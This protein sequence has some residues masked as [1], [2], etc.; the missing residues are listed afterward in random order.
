MQDNCVDVRGTGKSAATTQMKACSGAA[1]QRFTADPRDGRT[2]AEVLAL[3]LGAP[4]GGG[5]GGATARP[6][7]A[8]VF[9]R[10]TTLVNA[11]RGAD[12]VSI[13]DG[14]AAL[15]RC[16]GWSAPGQH[17][18]I[19][20]GRVMSGA[21][22]LEFAPAARVVEGGRLPGGLPGA[23]VARSMGEA[24]IR[25][26]VASVPCSLA[27]EQRFTRRGDE[28]V[29][30][31][32][33]CVAPTPDALGPLAAVLGNRLVA[34]ACTG[35]ASQ[36]FP[37]RPVEGWP[38]PVEVGTFV[39][40]TETGRISKWIRAETCPTGPCAVG[41]VQGA[42][43]VE[44]TT[45]FVRK[46]GL[47]DPTAASFELWGRP[48]HWLRRDGDHLRLA[49]FEDS[50]AFRADATFR[51]TDVPPTDVCPNPPACPT[52]Y[53]ALSPLSRP[54][55]FVTR[56]GDEFVIAPG[57]VGRLGT[58]AKLGLVKMPPPKNYV[59]RDPSAYRPLLSALGD[60]CLSG[61]SSGD[62]GWVDLSPCTAAPGQYWG[63][64]DDGGLVNLANQLCLTRRGAPS[65]ESPYATVELK[66]CTGQPDQRWARVGQRTFEL[67]HDNFCLDVASPYPLASILIDRREGRPGQTF[68]VTVPDSFKRKVIADFSP[69]LQFDRG[70]KYFPSSVEFFLKHM[71]R[72]QR[73]YPKAPPKVRDWQGK[74][75]SLR[76]AEALPTPQS[77]LK[78]FAGEATALEDVP[79]YAFWVPRGGD[80]V[81]VVY[82]IFYPYNLGKT[83]RGFLK[84][85]VRLLDAGM[86]LLGLRAGKLSFETPAVGN[87]VGDWEHVTARVRVTWSGDTPKV[88]PLQYY[89]ASHDEGLTANYERNADGT[90]Q[91]TAKDPDPFAT[92]PVR[93]APLD[94]M[95]PQTF[96]AQGSHGSYLWVGEH[97]YERLMAE[98]ISRGVLSAFDIELDSVE[99]MVDL[100]SAGRVWDP[101]A[102]IVAWDFGNQAG[103]TGT[104]WPSWLMEGG[105]VLGSDPS[106]PESGSIYRWGNAAQGMA[107]STENELNDGPVGPTW[108]DVLPQDPNNPNIR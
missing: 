51:A 104:A 71:V 20:D 36:A 1:K 33:S 31:D 85:P 64:N 27:P 84:A 67:R 70:E 90:Y 65:P 35:A 9:E 49:P 66:K 94:G 58:E 101:R 99:P 95:R 91:L 52:V 96:V 34:V 24:G 108:K 43:G 25:G 106:R 76:T 23:L 53:T 75:W 45:I 11:L 30:S 46:T 89:F 4:A 7:P 54:G 29:V 6:E 18:R 57:E 8:Y 16:E 93:V 59:P 56:R 80:I 77:T 37:L 72:E 73:W 88:E 12:C 74:V 5:G 81:D 22:C 32:G 83:V 61:A 2:S 17:F 47:A 50:L 103:L 87:H 13:A 68:L 63:V 98:E 40:F 28:L 82:Y 78:Y 44:Q 39:I 41:L 26:L 69:I 19:Q 100:T 92:V 21:T 97:F 62:S 107:L 3:L 60:K 55:A 42:P 86:K 10:P 105:L 14:L 48:G 102:R 15:Q 79:I 38:M